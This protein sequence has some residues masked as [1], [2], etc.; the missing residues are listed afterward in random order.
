VSRQGE[1]PILRMGDAADT[2]NMTLLALRY[3]TRRGRF[4]RVLDGDKDPGRVAGAAA[5]T[6]PMDLSREMKMQE[7]RERI[8]HDD[9]RVDAQAIAGAIVERLLAGVRRDDST[10]DD[11]QCS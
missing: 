11:R 4:G 10:G 9:Y 3:D 6:D 1:D 7:I 2:R 5:D 8:E